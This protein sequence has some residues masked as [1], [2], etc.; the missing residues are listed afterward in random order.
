MEDTIRKLPIRTRLI[1]LDEEW[2][3]WSFTARMNPP[4]VVF[5]QIGSG[6]LSIIAQALAQILI[7]WNYVDTLGN[8]LPPPNLE[9]IRAN[10]PSEL[11]VATAN[12]WAEEMTT[13]P[14]A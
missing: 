3:G 5:E 4:L 2:A 11:I 14:P 9:V 8:A 12:K 10:L 7:S 13:V 1:E 6:D